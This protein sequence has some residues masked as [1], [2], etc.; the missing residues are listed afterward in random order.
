M[1]GSL[2]ELPAPLP[3]PASDKD[4][5][6]AQHQARHRAYLDQLRAAL[7]AEHERTGVPMCADD[8]HRLIA[9]SES[10]RMPADMSALA[11]GSLFTGDK[12]ANG[13]ARWEQVGLVESTRENARG[14]LLRSWRLR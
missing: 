10:L 14:N 3:A 9:L 8:A 11:L 7:R 5:I 2:F 12:D 13:R 1:Q 4:R 6:L